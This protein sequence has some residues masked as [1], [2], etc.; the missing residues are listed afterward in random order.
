MSQTLPS[1]A[2]SAA[3]AQ[4]ATWRGAAAPR[5]ATPGLS[6]KLEPITLAQHAQHP[7]QAPAPPRGGP[8]ARAPPAAPRGGPP[9]PPPRAGGGGGGPLPGAVARRDREGDG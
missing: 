4:A 8:G 5:N 1:P 3:L 6:V 7:P 2:R 9:A